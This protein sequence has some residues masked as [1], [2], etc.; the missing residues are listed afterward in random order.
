MYITKYDTI[1]RLMRDG[2]NLS[3]VGAVDKRLVRLK[4]MWSKK[5]SNII[6]IFLLNQN[7]FNAP[8]SVNIARF[9]VKEQD[10]RH[11]RP[12]RLKDG[13]LRLPWTLVNDL[14][15]YCWDD[16][17]DECQYDVMVIGQSRYKK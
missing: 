4:F 5:D 12:P 3:I 8:H 7:E 11:Y 17:I 16:S 1:E 2:R 10:I 6:D 15:M 14:F 9:Y 13:Q